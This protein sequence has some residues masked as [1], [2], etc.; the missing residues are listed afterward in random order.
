MV[1]AESGIRLYRFLI[2][3]FLS[4]FH[5]LLIMTNN[6]QNVKV[7]FILT[8]TRIIKRNK[9]IYIFYIY[10]VHVLRAPYHANDVHSG[11]TSGLKGQLYY[12]IGMEE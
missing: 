8:I 5:I 9:I 1:G 10:T 12:N 6:L 11:H 2:I 4:T 7:L 3:A